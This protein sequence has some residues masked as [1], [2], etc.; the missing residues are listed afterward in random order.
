MET[1]PIHDALATE[2]AVLRSRVARLE[3]QEDQLTPAGSI[4]HGGLIGLADDDHPQYVLEALCHVYNS[5]NISIPDSVETILTFDSERYDT[6]TMHSVVGNTGRITF[7][8]AGKYH[9]TALATF[10]GNATGVRYIC[11]YLSATGTKIGQTRWP[12][13]GA[14]IGVAM[15]C[16]VE[17]EFAAGDY[18]TVYAWQNS[19]GAL[20]INTLANFSPVF[21]A[22]R[23]G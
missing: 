3:H 14:A 7:T 23:I 5:A 22:H 10:A 21:M 1:D 9:V 20:N 19:G 18:V 6:D 16:A 4:D 11:F 17:Y 12:N 13:F 8:T 15:L 2:I